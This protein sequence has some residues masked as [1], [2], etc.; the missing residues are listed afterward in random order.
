M[1]VPV[2][3]LPADA[4]VLTV[5]LDATSGAD[6]RDTTV[7]HRWSD[8]R[9]ALTPE[10]VDAVP[11]VDCDAV[12]EALGVPVHVRGEFGRVLV[13]AGGE[14]VLDRLLPEPPRADRA[15]VSDRPH[16]FAL[17]RAADATVRY[18]LVTVDRAGADFA[19][20]D[21]PAGLTGEVE[22]S[23][24][25][26][27]GHDALTKP[28]LGPLGHKRIDNRAEDSWERNAEAVATEL[29]RI[30]TARGPELVLLTGDLRAVALVR[31]EL[32]RPVREKVVEISGGG[33]AEGVNARALRDQV[34]AAQTELRSRRR[35]ST[36]E[37]F[38]QEAGRDGAAVSGA[39]AVLDVLRKGQVAELMLAPDVAGPP[40]RLAKRSLWIGPGSLELARDAEDL[41]SLGVQNP[42]EVRADLAIGRAVLE[43]GAGI[44]IAEEMDAVPD[45]VGALLRWHDS[46]TPGEHAL[47]GSADSRRV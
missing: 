8:L 46:G 3:D 21:A 28:N 14:V 39:E 47:A 19:L 40:S 13:A 27:G 32:G 30:Y 4:P 16:A 26:E 15:V 10:G 36:V 24:T 1:H 34:A 5:I 29:E 11:S 31:E 17:A 41:H 45:G 18:L 22:E 38:R 9:R 43:Q 7:L 12:T 33:R 44:T 35:T 42:R 23:R 25:V 20:Y 6:S 2:P 37:K